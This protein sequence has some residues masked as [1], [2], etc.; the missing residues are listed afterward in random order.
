MMPVTQTEFATPLP[1]NLREH[2]M[3]IGC[4]SK[5]AS[6]QRYVVIAMQQRPD[7]LLTEGQVGVVLRDW[8]EVHQVINSLR[9]QATIAWGPSPAKPGG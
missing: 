7:Q 6:G 1:V 3:L 2:D 8:D 5:P 9:G 4:V